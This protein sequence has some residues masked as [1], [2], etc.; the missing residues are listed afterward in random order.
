M[1]DDVKKIAAQIKAIKPD[2]I[3]LNTVVRPPAEDFAGA[4][5]ENR[6][7]ALTDLFDPPASVITD[8][9]VTNTE[10]VR[11]TEDTIMALLLIHVDCP[12]Q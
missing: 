6:M 1:P 8:Y 4:L 10:K 3:H 5:P 7:K 12:R 2:Q 9:H 11:I